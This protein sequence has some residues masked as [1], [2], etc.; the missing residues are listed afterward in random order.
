MQRSWQVALTL[1]VSAILA[2][3]TTGFSY[4]VDN[5]VE[6]RTAHRILLAQL[7]AAEES[8]EALDFQI[9]P[10]PLGSAM[11]AFADQANYRLLIPSHMTEG[12]DT[13]G[14]TG[15]H[16]P[17]EALGILLGG[18]GLSYRM[19]ETRTLTLERTARPM[20]QPTHSEA[21]PAPRD[22]TPTARQAAPKPVKVPEIVVKEVEE[23]DYAVDDSSSVMRIPVP[24][25]ETPRS[26]EVVTRQ[27]LDDQRI[28]R[29]SDALRNVSGTSQSSTQGG[30]QE[31]VLLIP[32]EA[33]V[34]KQNQ[35]FVYRAQD[36]KA[37]QTEVRLG[38]RTGGFVQVLTELEE[39]DVI[40]LVGH[41]KL[42]DGESILAL[43]T[44]PR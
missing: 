17:E 36:G 21:A 31:R 23:H 19:T 29:F 11:T 7:A 33:V 27:V 32:E 25:E 16:T 43:S 41:H 37:H 28:I 18:T 1:S 40:V 35:T 3:A 22:Q 4:G 10:Q 15:R 20:D 44:T 30:H 24:I 38:T 5:L 14:V 2:Q 8:P 39:Q 6:G 26:V 9:P 34:P 42:R 12:I 13:N